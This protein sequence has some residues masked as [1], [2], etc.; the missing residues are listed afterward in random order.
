M[1]FSIQEATNQQQE[2]IK[3]AVEQDDEVTLF[4]YAKKFADTDG[5][6][7]EVLLELARKAQNNNWAYDRHVDNCLV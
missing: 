4:L 5:E 7:A 2:A 1:S 3:R 6:Y